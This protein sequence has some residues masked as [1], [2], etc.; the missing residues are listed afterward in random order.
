M[1]CEFAD[2]LYNY[3]IHHACI[4]VMIPYTLSTIKKLGGG[5]I[6][7]AIMLAF[8][9]IL[10]PIYIYASTV[11]NDFLFGVSFLLLSVELIY[12]LYDRETYFSKKRHFLLTA[13]A[14]LGTFLRYNGIYAI[15]LTFA[16]VLLREICY[17]IKNKSKNKFV[18]IASLVLAFIIPITSGLVIQRSLNKF[19]DAKS[20]TTRAMLAMPIQQ[21]VRCL[22]DHSSEIPAQEYEAIHNVLTWTDEEYAKEYYARNFDSVK[23]S[24]KTDATKQEIA[25]FI[26]A[27]LKLVK[28]YPKTCFM[29]T[30]EQTYYLFCPFVENTRYYVSTLQCSVL[31]EPRTGMDPSPYIFSMPILEKFSNLLN[32]V[33][34]DVYP[35]IPLIGFTVSQGA[36]TFLLFVMSVALLF[37]KDRRALLLTVPMY[38]ILGITFLGPAV[39]NH[40]RYTY[41]IMYCMPVLIFAYILSM[42]R[43]EGLHD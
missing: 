12:Y 34:T 38:I 35:G 1:I 15:A 11:Y 5:N 8:F 41:P 31:I 26:K 2:L 43:K 30:A 7:L 14:V 37:R 16:V 36:Y 10:P 33:L 39:Y 22:K 13:I 24:F 19:Y 18:V 20:I 4:M 23:N 27:W 17:L 40:P 6:T 28:L 9:V 21:T 32:M 42:P 25:S 3:S 29:A